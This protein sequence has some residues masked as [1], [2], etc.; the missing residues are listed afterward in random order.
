MAK[1]NSLRTWMVKMKIAG[2]VVT[3]GTSYA[4]TRVLIPSAKVALNGISAGHFCI[5]LRS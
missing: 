4:V 5:V 3:V 2:G 1:V